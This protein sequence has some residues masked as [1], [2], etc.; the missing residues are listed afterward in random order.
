MERLIHTAHRVLTRKVT[1]R[2][3]FQ[4]QIAGESRRDLL[5]TVERDVES[6]I[7]ACQASDFAHV[8]MYGIALSNVPCCVGMSDA[9]GIVERHYGF[10]FCQS[11]RDHFRSAVEAGEEVRFY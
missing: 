4:K 6:K 9:F 8:I 10:E 2:C 7:H 11:R 1:C 5:I 3:M